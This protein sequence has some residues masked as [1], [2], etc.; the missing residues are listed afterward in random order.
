MGLSKYLGPN[1]S[2]KGFADFKKTKTDMLM[3]VSISSKFEV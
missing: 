1:N 3:P 2:E